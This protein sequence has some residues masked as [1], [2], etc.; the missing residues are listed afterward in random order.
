[1][2]SHVAY[3]GQLLTHCVTSAALGS[4]ISLLPL[5]VCAIT[6]GSFNQLKKKQKQKQKTFFETDVVCSSLAWNF[7]YDGE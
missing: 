2:G 5:Q 1:M 4:L 6:P 7:Q 3:E